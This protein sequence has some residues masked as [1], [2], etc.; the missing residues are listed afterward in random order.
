MSVLKKL[1]PLEARTSF[2]PADF[3]PAPDFSVCHYR[4]GLDFHRRVNCQR[5]LIR[6]LGGMIDIP[7]NIYNHPYSVLPCLSFWTAEKPWCSATLGDPVA[8]NPKNPPGLSWIWVKTA[9]KKIILHQ[10]EI[11][12]LGEGSFLIFFNHSFYCEVDEFF[13]QSRR[14]KAYCGEHLVRSNP[15]SKNSVEEC[16]TTRQIERAFNQNGSNIFDPFG[17]LLF[18]SL[19]PRSPRTTPLK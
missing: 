13:H 8:S 7:M 6:W 10:Q 4:R 18:L 17:D 2:S 16:K 19:L 12:S 15:N 3:L 14:L 9:L 11:I 5:W 1:E